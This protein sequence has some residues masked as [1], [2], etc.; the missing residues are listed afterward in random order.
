MVPRVRGKTRAHLINFAARKMTQCCGI[1]IAPWKLMLV[2]LIS[3][4]IPRTNL[5]QL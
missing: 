2:D 1:T 3:S 5:S 4:V